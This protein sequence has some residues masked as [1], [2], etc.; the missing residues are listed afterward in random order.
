MEANPAATR[1]PTVLTRLGALLIL[2]I[3]G[4]LVG[5][6]VALV[7]SFI[8]LVIVFPIGMAFA[9]SMIA[10]SAAQVA[11][12]RRTAQVT[13]IFILTALV[14][15]GSFHYGRYVFFQLG[16]WLKLASSEAA[17]STGVQ[18]DLKLAKVFTDFAL[19]QETGHTGFLGYMLYRAKTGLSIGKFYSQNR[20][21]L[22]GVLAWLYW[23]LE[24]GLILWIM[25]GEVKDHL[26]V[27]VCESC[28]RRLGREQHLG[29]TTPANEPL[30][31]DL[32][33][34]GEVSGLGQMLV[35]E[36]GLPSVELYMQKCKTCGQQSTSVITVRRASLG[37]RGVVLAEISQ[38]S[39]PP[40]DST[41]FL[42]QLQFE[43]D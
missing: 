11:R 40:Q 22:N 42:Q 3:G 25:S 23:V 15:Y 5:M 2:V 29:G 9:G 43:V 6:G 36:A 27:P 24:F 20:L 8:Y 28:G 31:L 38:A 13:L 32:L 10:S 18:V 1:K 34:R 16:S 12:V 37:R 26:R 39:L 21:S 7:G 14:V 19:K 4:G 41:L 17:Q 35:K 33:K 30:L